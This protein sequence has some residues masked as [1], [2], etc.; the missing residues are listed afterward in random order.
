MVL[1]RS[2]KTVIINAF[3]ID[4]PARPL[5]AQS[6]STINEKYSAGP[7]S[8]AILDNGF[9]SRISPIRAIIPAIKEPIAA[10]AR[11][12]PARPCRAI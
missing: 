12:T 2:P 4:F 9:A 11:A 1:R 6:P 10:I 5:T 7:N 8:R 3:V